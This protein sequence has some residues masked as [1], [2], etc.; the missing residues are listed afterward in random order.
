MSMTQDE[1]ARKLEE[2]DHLLNDPDVPLDPS[3]VWSLLA[4]LSA[5][6]ALAATHASVRESS[7]LA[8]AP[9]GEAN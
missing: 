2:L 6:Q 3:R 1:Y 7:A 8:A 4:D 5:R 9:G